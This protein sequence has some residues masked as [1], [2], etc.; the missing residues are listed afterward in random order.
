MLEFI[1]EIEHENALDMELHYEGRERS[2]SF[3]NMFDLQSS[4][5]NCTFTQINLDIQDSEL[6]F[7]G[8]DGSD[9]ETE[10]IILLA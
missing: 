8:T 7:H 2:S 3:V 5:S 6:E 1:A 9:M 10:A 4:E